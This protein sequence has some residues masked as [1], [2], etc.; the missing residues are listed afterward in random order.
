ML[1]PLSLP[2]LVVRRSSSSTSLT[3]VGA[4]RTSHRCWANPP[5]RC[6][7]ACCLLLLITQAAIFLAT[8]A[9]ASANAA[10]LLAQFVKGDL[11]SG[12]LL[13]YV[14]RSES[15]DTVLHFAAQVGGPP[16]NG[17]A[18]LLE[19]PDIEGGMGT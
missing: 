10:C 13:S 19:V 7:S 17:S 2:C 11:Q 8:G 3:T 14:L 5:S 9:H 4:S 18:L 16:G 15:V 1:L 12:D 6:T